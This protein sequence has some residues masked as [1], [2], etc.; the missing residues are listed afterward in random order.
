MTTRLWLLVTT[1]AG[2]QG[3]VVDRLIGL[4]GV[5]FV[6]AVGVSLGGF[7]I[8]LATGVMESISKVIKPTVVDAGLTTDEVAR[9]TDEVAG[10]ITE[11]QD[12]RWNPS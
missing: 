8:R 6:A 2:K 5:D 7:V 12:T 3:L 4:V 11:V 9:P 10:P 1:A